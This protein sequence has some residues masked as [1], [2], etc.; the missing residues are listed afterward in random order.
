MESDPAAPPS[1]SQQAEDFVGL[2]PEDDVEVPG[3]YFDALN[4]NTKLGKAIRAACDELNHLSA[5]E[6]ESLKQADVLLKKL[7]VKSSIMDVPAAAVE[8]PIADGD[9]AGHADD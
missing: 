4:P 9:A 1:S 8:E 2:A 6:L 3:T 7:G 5:M